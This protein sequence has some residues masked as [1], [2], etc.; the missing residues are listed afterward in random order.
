MVNSI[1]PGCGPIKGYTQI[2]ARGKN[3]MEFGFGKAKC[4]FNGT[5]VMNATIIDKNN[6]YCDSPP[7]DTSSGDMWYN[8]SIS[9]DGNYKTEATSVFKYYEDPTISSVSPG[10]GPLRGSTKVTI[11]G[12]GFNETNFCDLTVRFGQETL[13]PRD[14]SANSLV[15]DSPAEN[16]PGS[17]VVSLSGNKQQYIDDRTLHFR[18]KE[19]TF[20]YY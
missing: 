4:I 5:I 6:L 10:M 13:I 11:E 8:M 9:L 2:L 18:D 14:V 16:V 3:Y 17:V 12:L 1:S 20:E 7:L 15:V 19:N